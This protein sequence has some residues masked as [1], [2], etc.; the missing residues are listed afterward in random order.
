M[1]TSTT[2]EGLVF[3]LL[4]PSTSIGDGGMARACR[5][6]TI[7]WSRFSFHGSI[8]E[9]DGVDDVLARALQGSSRYCFIQWYGHLIS[10]NGLPVDGGAVDFVAALRCWLEVTDFLV[11][12][13]LIGD[14]SSFFGFERRCLVVD[15]DRY[16]A[17]GCPPFGPPAAQPRELPVPSVITSADGQ[18][19]LAPTGRRRSAGPRNPG[20][21]LI[22]AALD[23]ALPVPELPAEVRG[24][25]LSLEPDKAAR[26]RALAPY[27]GPGLEAFDPEA[28]DPR[29]SEEGLSSEQVRFLRSV[30]LQT[31][32]ARK[33]VGLWNIES[34]ADV[35][36]PEGFAGPLSALYCVAQGFKPNMILQRLGFTHRTR[37][38]F[39][40]YSRQALAVR[41]CIVDEWDGEDFPGFVRHLF[42]VFPA[43]ETHYYLWR[44][45]RPDEIDWD[46]MD[47]LW[48]R[49]L[50]AWGGGRSFRDHWRAYRKLP[51]EY[52]DCNLLGAT[53]DLLDAIEGQG[54]AAIWWSN[55][56]F[57]IYSNWYL[58]LEERRRRYRAWIEALAGRHPDLCLFGSDYAN[59]SVNNARAST[60]W[61]RFRDLD[62]G[63]LEPVRLHRRQILV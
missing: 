23:N 45:L 60:Y 42:Q 28:Q 44:G 30:R 51:H 10:P 13:T 8:L 53:S 41:K 43:P 29:G 18:R 9:G 16:R 5:D 36:P 50:D 34:Y 55:A 14:E 56:Y 40:D 2:R 15:L 58:S 61:S 7:S 25:T 62:G 32:V 27:L 46:D 52:L 39:F 37:V 12:G 35:E 38:V 63:G 6:L 59:N 54:A 57:T 20:W 33:A 49:E 1:A 3:G 11:A 21:S 19:R 31:A 24:H 26:R 22:R 17:F 4:D 48:R 47:R